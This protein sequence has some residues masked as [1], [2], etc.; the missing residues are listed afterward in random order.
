MNIEMEKPTK[1]RLSKE[2]TETIIRYDDG[3]NEC[4]IYTCN[5]A[6]VARLD[7]YCQSNPKQWKLY[8]EDQYSKTYTTTKKLLTIR[9]K[10]TKREMTDEEK[11]AAGE[12]LRKHRE[13]QQ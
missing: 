11:Q 5:K 12:R 7:R 13:K 10:S 9:E 6:L 8:G 2:E 1:Y 3:S 4:R